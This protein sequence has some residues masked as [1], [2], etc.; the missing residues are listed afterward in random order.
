[1]EGYEHCF[2]HLKA[3]GIRIR[4]PPKEKQPIAKRSKKQRGIM[5]ELSLMYPVFLEQHPECEIR[6]LGCL[7]I[8]TEVHHVK[9]RIGDQVFEVVDWR[10]SC[11]YCNCALENDPEAHKKGLKKS[12]HTK[13][14][15]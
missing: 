9:G 12:I 6:L 13:S 4:T 14:E 15:P 1:M 2:D 10:A 11:S 5:K 7:R 8:A 3:Q